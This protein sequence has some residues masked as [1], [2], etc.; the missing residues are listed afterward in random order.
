MTGRILREDD[1]ATWTLEV[2]PPAGAGERR[3]LEH[4]VRL[5]TSE[6]ARLLERTL[7]RPVRDD[8]LVDAVAWVDQ[9]RGEELACA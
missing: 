1:A 7:R 6:T 3:R 5:V 2:V 8:A 9:L 4:R